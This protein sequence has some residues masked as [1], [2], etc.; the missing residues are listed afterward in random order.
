MVDDDLTLLDLYEA[1]FEPCYTILLADNVEQAIRILN[2]QHV[3]AVGCD[4]HVG[5]GKGLDVLDWIGRNKPELLKRSVLISGES[6]ADLHDLK[7]PVLLKPVQ[8]SKLEEIFDQ[9][10]AEGHMAE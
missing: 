3:D 10:M 7:V 2:E 9:F 1:V 6:S 4:L 8:V 5:A